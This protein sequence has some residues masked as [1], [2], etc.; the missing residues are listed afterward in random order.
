[1]AVMGMIN[2]KR[3][4]PAMIAPAM[5]CIFLFDIPDDFLTLPDFFAIIFLL[6]EWMNKFYPVKMTKGLSRI[7]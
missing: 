5:T 3:N 4:S 7:G 6:S 1:M 2:P